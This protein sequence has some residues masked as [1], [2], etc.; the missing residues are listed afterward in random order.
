MKKILVSMFVI[1]MVFGVVGMAS[2]VPCTWTDVLTFND[3]Q[4]YVQANTS[5]NT[6]SYTHDISDDGFT[7]NLLTE[8]V[9]DYSII[10]GIK[11]DS[12]DSSTRF[13]EKI[14]ID[15]PGWIGDY[16]E[17]VISWE[18]ITL[19]WSFA[20]IISLNIDGTLDITITA[21]KGDFIV[22]DSTLEANGEGT[23]NAPVPEPATMLL[24]GSGL[25][26]LG[27]LRRKFF[28]K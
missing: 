15:Q 23:A 8:Y 10:I 11:D 12:S 20:G 19:G 24:L 16:S 3:T 18:D 13:N 27:G 4:G 28:K 2:A 25:I 21:L 7:F 6:L 22:T 14:E 9:T 5:N 17:N 1:L 26:G